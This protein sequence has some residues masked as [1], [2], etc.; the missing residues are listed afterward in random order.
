MKLKRLEKI[1][2]ALKSE[3]EKNSDINSQQKYIDVSNAIEELLKENNEQKAIIQKYKDELNRLKG[4]QGKP[5]VRPQS[6]NNSKGE[7]DISS[8]NERKQRQAKKTK[9]KRAKKKTSIKIDRKKTCTLDKSN[10]PDDAVKKGYKTTV[11]QDL[12]LTTENTKF[13]REVWHSKSLNKTFIAPLPSGYTGDYGP[14]LRALVIGLYYDANVTEPA[15]Y[16]LLTTAGICISNATISRMLTDKHELFHQ[17]KKD[18]VSVGMNAPYHNLDDTTGRVNG[19]NHYV[20][21][22][23]SEYFTAFFTKPKKDRLTLLEILSGQPLKFLFNDDSFNLMSEIG[24][25]EKRREIF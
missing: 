3:V 2:A 8:E 22:L 5:K 25:P 11:I 16:Q 24:L 17:E 1:L 23:S 20:H 6:K 18:I 21:I 7:G 10:L 13:E 19:K 12:F 14:N 9:K 15:I 4:E